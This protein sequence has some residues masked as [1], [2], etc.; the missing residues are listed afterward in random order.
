[1]S[2]SNNI[3]HKAVARYAGKT[4]KRLRSQFSDHWN[5]TKLLRAKGSYVKS[6]RLWHRIRNEMK[7]KGRFI[8]EGRLITKGR[9][10]GS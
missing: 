6:C 3:R 1:M 4:K 9:K 5:L 7:E 10:V 2:E 8:T